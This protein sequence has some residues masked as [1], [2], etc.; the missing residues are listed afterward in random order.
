MELLDYLGNYD[1]GQKLPDIGLF[2]PSSNSILDATENDYASLRIGAVKTEREATT[3]TIYATGRYKPEDQ[4]EYETDHWGY[5]ESDFLEAFSLTDLTE[6]ETALIDSF[7][8]VATEEAGGFAEFRETATKTNSLIERLKDITLPDLNDVKDDLRR[9]NE[10]KKRADDLDEKIERTDELIDEI[11][12]EIYG[13]TE[14][15]IEII[16]SP[17]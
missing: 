14:E 12:F 16:E 8:P 11:V 1:E 3:V 17:L 2:Q 15:E 10:V 7:V 9:Y 6:N 5:T 13:L 4:A